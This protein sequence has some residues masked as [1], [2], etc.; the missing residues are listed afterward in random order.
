MKCIFFYIFF[1]IRLNP[2]SVSP[3]VL[4]T[5]TKYSHTCMYIFFSYIWQA[6]IKKLKR[7]KCLTTVNSNKPY[8]K[9][10]KKV[11]IV[12]GVHKNCSRQG[13]LVFLYI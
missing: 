13:L 11:G 7:T 10:E 12:D 3:S 4:C 6:E 1:T 9:L 8:L 2:I 5:V